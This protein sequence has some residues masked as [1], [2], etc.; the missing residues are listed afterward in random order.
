MT[1][2]RKAAK[3][4]LRAG[5]TR[6]LALAIQ[7]LT[8]NESDWLELLLIDGFWP[9]LG[10]KAFDYEIL[11]QTERRLFDN[12]YKGTAL[13]LQQVNTS[14][15]DLSLRVRSLVKQ[16]K[17][18]DFYRQD[19]APRI[20]A[21]VTLI[22]TQIQA[23]IN[24]G[25]RLQRGGYFFPD[26]AVVTK[27]TEEVG[28]VSVNLADNL[29]A[30]CEVAELA[31]R[32]SLHQAENNGFG[33]LKEEIAIYENSDFEKALYA[34]VYWVRLNDLWAYVKYSGWRLNDFEGRPVYSPINPDRHRQEA[35]GKFRHQLLMSEIYNAQLPHS[36]QIHEHAQRLASTI[37]LPR[38]I[39]ETWDCKVDISSCERGKDTEWDLLGEFI[40]RLFGYQPVLERLKISEGEITIR[41]QEWFKGR[42]TLNFL[43]LVLTK[44]TATL[45]EEEFRRSVVRVDIA[46]LA[47]LIG[48][49]LGMTTDRSR[50]LVSSF[51]M[52]A[53]RKRSEIWDRPLIPLGDGTVL[54]SPNL[55]NI[56]SAYRILENIIAEYDDSKAFHYS[57]KPFEERITEIWRNVEG[58]AIAQEKKVEAPDGRQ[59]EFDLVVYWS[60]HL[61]L[62]EVKCL[63]SVQSPADSHRARSSIAYAFEQ[64]AK[65]RKAVADNWEW[66]LD[67]FQDLSLPGEALAPERIHTIAITNL[68]AFSPETQGNSVL[69][70]ALC[71]ERYFQN[72]EMEIFSQSLSGLIE[73]IGTAGFIRSG[74]PE[75]TGLIKYLRNPPQAKRVY[76][77]LGL[78]L[79]YLLPW[80]AEDQP[81]FYLEDTFSGVHNSI[82]SKDANT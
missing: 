68:V 20:V 18:I 30:I 12:G 63:K 6:A 36:Y 38:S 22:E 46:T 69:T 78:T 37:K 10:E 59:I 58:A 39:N 50:A 13:R 16:R 77:R 66:F 51:V 55:V 8:H 21:L 70:D 25:S 49:R 67:T 4:A 28:R 44:A 41:W 52:D 43:A 26:Q 35:A 74:P 56:G 2:Y 48:D 5:D 33:D 1:D 54:F 45:P 76:E 75:P 73:K 53:K 40:I 42:S 24:Q 32:E 15:K 34:A 23:S 62:M 14:Y 27:S 72:P 9:R 81:L 19:P 60:G 71:L 61:L 7:G 79:G 82:E 3:D 31:I 57:G 65:R 11:S 64:L 80:S 47:G 29:E 17:K